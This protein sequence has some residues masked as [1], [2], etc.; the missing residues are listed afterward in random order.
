MKQS[1]CL[2]ST[3][4]DSTRVISTH[5]WKLQIPQSPLL[6]PPPPRLPPSLLISLGSDRDSV[7]KWVMESEIYDIGLD[8]GFEEF[9]I[10]EVGIG[11]CR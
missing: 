9:D 5:L 7:S 10:L 2:I 1:P 11:P 3:P 4:S 8:A 6:Y